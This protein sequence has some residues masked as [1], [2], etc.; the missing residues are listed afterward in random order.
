MADDM[1]DRDI[2][3]FVLYRS[4]KMHRGLEIASHDVHKR[5]VWGGSSDILQA[6][7][8]Y[9]EITA[10]CQLRSDANRLSLMSCSH[11]ESA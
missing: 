3:R 11:G 2:C 1:M 5:G 8:I 6:N 10:M 4:G 7:N 9:L